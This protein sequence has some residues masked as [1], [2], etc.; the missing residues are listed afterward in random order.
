VPPLLGKSLFI[1]IIMCV[2]DVRVY[3][4]M[5]TETPLWGGFL[6]LP[7]HEV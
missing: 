5:C 3:C 1:I 4:G 7:L 2:H 6:V